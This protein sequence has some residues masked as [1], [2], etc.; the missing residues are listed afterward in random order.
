MSR[1]SSWHRW[2]PV[3]VSLAVGAGSTGCGVIGWAITPRA[4]VVHYTVPRVE[5]VEVRSL[6]EGAM[7]LVD[8]A[9]AGRTPKAVK[10]PL[11]EVRAQR[12]Q[13]VVP[14]LV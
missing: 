5:E 11:T 3:L 13:S 7:V 6:P 1:P 14:G 12:R 4:E 8:G 10:V 2:V 9:E